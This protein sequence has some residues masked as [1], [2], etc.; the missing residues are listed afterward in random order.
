MFLWALVYSDANSLG[1]EEC[2]ELKEAGSNDADE[3]SGWEETSTRATMA[4]KSTPVAT[5]PPRPTRI[6]RPA[7]LRT[8]EAVADLMPDE[9]SRTC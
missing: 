7:R 3:N 1:A 9:F 2:T 5:T 6:I 8:A 4:A